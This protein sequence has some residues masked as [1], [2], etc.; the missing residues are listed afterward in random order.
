MIA[1]LV[2]QYPAVS[3]TFI[4]RE[5]VALERQGID[6][7]RFAVRSGNS[8]VDP[9]DLQEQARTSY[10]LGHPSDLLLAAAWAVATRPFGFLTALAAAAKMMRHSDRSRPHSGRGLGRT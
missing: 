1:Y 8:L 6:V 7:T 9:G 2:N 3:H 5:I 10:L 4:K